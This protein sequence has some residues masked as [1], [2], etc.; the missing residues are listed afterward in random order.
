MEIST[1]GDLPAKVDE[2]I[3]FYQLVAHSI[4]PFWDELGSKKSIKQVVQEV[5]DRTLYDDDE[6]S[7]IIQN[8]KTK[9]QMD[10]MKFSIFPKNKH[11][12]DLK[13]LEELQNTPIEKTIAKLK[14]QEKEPDKRPEGAT[15]SNKEHMQIMSRNT[16]Q[17]PVEE[18]QQETKNIEMENMLTGDLIDLS[19]AITDRLRWYSDINIEK[20]K[21]ITEKKSIRKEIIKFEEITMKSFM[22]RLNKKY[23]LLRHHGFGI[24]M[25]STNEDR[26]YSVIYDEFMDTHDVSDREVLL[27]EM[28]GVCLSWLPKQKVYYRAKK[29]TPV[30]SAGTKGSADKSES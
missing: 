28:V 5:L 25:L 22:K 20:I 10:D 29:I 15:K 19:I 2:N 13:K 27:D 8:K 16:T 7:E 9:S 14:Q 17:L 24:D 6:S 30:V 18:N 4:I 26:P 1:F 21:S 23:D 12:E 3:R 11:L